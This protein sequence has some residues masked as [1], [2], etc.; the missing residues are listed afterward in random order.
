MCLFLAMVFVTVMMI[1]VSSVVIVAIQFLYVFI[2]NG[3]G[4]HLYAY[5]FLSRGGC[6]NQVAQCSVHTN[7]RSVFSFFLTFFLFCVMVLVMVFVVLV[8]SY[9]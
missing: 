3:C 6:R 5:L 1:V 7:E 2:T 9:S 8:L 4:Q